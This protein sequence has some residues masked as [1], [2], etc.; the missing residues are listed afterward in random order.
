MTIVLNGTTGITTP[1]V[2]TTT[3]TISGG[4]ANGVQY[5]NGSK[6][7]TAG[8]ALTFDGT[9]LATTGSVSAPN[10]FG[11]KNRIINGAMVIDQRNAG[12]SVTPADGAYTLDRYVVNVS[13]AS[14]LSIQQTT[15]AP[16]GF[17][18]SLKV[19][20]LS[21]YA[22]LA[23]DYFA[24]LQQIEGFNTADLSFGTANAKT[25][26]LSFW[27]Q[28]SLTGAFGGALM[29][30]AQNRSY[31]F[32]YTISVANTWEQKTIT[33]AGDTSGT[34][35][36]STNGCGMRVIFGLGAGST[37]GGGTANAWTGGTFVMAPTGS[38]S[39]VGTNGATW[40]ITGVQLEKGSVAT[41]FDFRDYGRE[42]IMC[43]RYC[44]IGDVNVTAAY[45]VSS[46]VVG[47]V[48]FKVTKRASPTLTYSG[49]P[50][51]YVNGTAPA[52]SSPITDGTPTVD[53]FNPRATSAAATG[54]YAARL[55]SYQFLATA[56]L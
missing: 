30:S 52:A 18:N 22:V 31:P 21:A 53:V 20:S 13:Q 28:S 44:E 8:S 6:A 10:T 54:G 36:G 45:I 47:S 24:V 42:L 50:S 32:S 9:N 34:W 56:E 1:D 35:I 39:V 48:Y 26:T 33:V 37:Y 14:K 41:S 19:T 27:V 40:Y 3:E 49:T 25:V 16:T 2:S 12:A 17:S 11:F 4:T 46:V 5:L 38:T 23:G 55:Y 29:N 15:T 7:V 51:I 43:Q